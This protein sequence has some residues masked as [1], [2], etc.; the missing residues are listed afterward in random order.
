MTVAEDKQITGTNSSGLLPL[1][2]IYGAASLL[3]FAHNAVYLRDYPNLPQWLTSTG[4]AAA[5]WVVALTGVFGYFLYSRVARLA[6]M[7][8]IA[9]YA[10]FGFGGLDHY[11]V[12]PVT[13]HTTGMNLTILLEAGS[14]L[15]LLICVARLALL[16]TARRSQVPR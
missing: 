11:A 10:L 6:G 4:V 12:A 16:M 7:L 5:W 8:T 14:S 3:H 13:A 15:A 2:L 9:V 1:M